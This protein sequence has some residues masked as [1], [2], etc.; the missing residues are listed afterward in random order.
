MYLIAASLLST[1]TLFTVAAPVTTDTITVPAGET[2]FSIDIHVDE[3]TDYAGIE[4]ALSIS[5]ENAVKFTSFTPKLSGATASPFETKGKLHYFGFYDYQAS[6]AFPAG[7][8]RIGTI[9]FANY[10][11]SQTLTITIEQMS[12][13]RLVGNKTEEKLNDESPVYVF[14]V[15]R[16]GGTDYTVIF[17]TNGGTR[18]SGGELVQIIHEGGGA[19]APIVTHSDYDFLGWDKDFDNITSDLTVTAQWGIR[20]YTVTFVL[21]GGTRTGGGELV[22]TVPKGGKAIA[23]TVTRNGFA[24]EG[25]DVDFSDISYDTTVTAQWRNIGGGG[26]GNPGSGTTV[27]DPETP[28]VD[29][30]HY[31]DD[32][33]E[34]NYSWALEAVDALAEAGVVKGTSE[35]IYSPALSIKRGDFTLMLARAYSIDDEFTENFPDVPEGSYYYDAIGSAK[36]RGVAKGFD[37]GL[38]HPNAT[39]RRQD[40]MVLIDRALQAI[41]KPL[42]PGDES[43]ISIFSDSDKISEYARESVMT[44]VKSGIIQGDGENVNPL[45]YTTR[46]EM[47]VA[48]YRLLNIKYE[49]TPDVEPDVD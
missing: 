34:N 43:D 13:T 4:F 30:S 47:A 37:D 7:E 3:P 19:V 29:L 8:T 31:F 18:T 14:T 2:S 32:V 28:L 33:D 17:D 35:R 36:E 38:F 24:F 15:R 16:P 6:N 9:Y 44:L 20:D 48:L 21:N 49:L 46:A 11:G 12:V 1:L 5:N 39:I 40:M 42:P 10:T 45:E 41:G 25:W 27:T 23:P 26:G 22:Q